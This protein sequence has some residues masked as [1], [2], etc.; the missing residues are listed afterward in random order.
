MKTRILFLSIIAI[1]TILFSSCEKEE[2]PYPSN[3]YNT[4][5]P[6]FNEGPTINRW[7]VF[8]V[9][10]AVMYINN[11]E[12]GEKIVCNHF[13]STKS[14][15]SLRWG[16]SIFDIETIIKDTT[17]YTFYEPISYPGN[18]RFVLNGDV[19][20]HYMVNY[21]GMYS[22]IIED[23]IYGA[24]EQLMGGSARPFSGKILNI[25]EM[26]IKIQIQEMVET[27]NGKDVRYWT[28]LTLKKI[29]EF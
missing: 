18:G 12:T 2:Y 22:T 16:G 26:T 28:E 9:I 5:V 20:K 13:S 23:P 11:L 27:I 7:G 15:S 24:T 25:N 4:T 14:R 10:D 8:L 3:D 1:A 6:N 29:E 19:S 17:T 21:I